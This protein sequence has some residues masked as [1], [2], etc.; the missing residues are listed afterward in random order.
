MQVDNNVN[1]A[2]MALLEFLRAHEHDVVLDA[3]AM[4]RLND[5]LVPAALQAWPALQGVLEQWYVIEPV[6]PWTAGGFTAALT[7]EEVFTLTQQLML[8][9]GPPV[10]LPCSF[11]LSSLPPLTSSSLSYSFKSAFCSFFC[12]YLRVSL[13]LGLRDHSFIFVLLS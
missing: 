10:P 2:M 11:L 3:A 7:R 8:Q 13:T 4:A 5:E 9:V 1:P 6:Y 12:L